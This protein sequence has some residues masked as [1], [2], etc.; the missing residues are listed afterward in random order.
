MAAC[1]SDCV[2][3]YCFQTVNVR[4]HSICVGVFLAGVVWFGV[5]FVFQEMITQKVVEMGIALQHPG[6]KTDFRRSSY[7]ISQFWAVL[8]I[9]QQL[10]DLPLEHCE[11]VFMISLHST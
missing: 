4:F 10:E 11:Q 3:F 2:P 8:G 5:W 7:V 6:T 1:K 9:P